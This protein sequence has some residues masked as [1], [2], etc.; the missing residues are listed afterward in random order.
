MQIKLSEQFRKDYKS[1]IHLQKQIKKQVDLFIQ[2]PQHPSLHT[3]KLYPKE[4]QRFSF[5][6]NKQYRIIYTYQDTI[7]V[8]L[9]ISKHYE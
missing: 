9:Y 5:R 7:P 4:Y 1:H 3:E 8:L 6:I 2:N